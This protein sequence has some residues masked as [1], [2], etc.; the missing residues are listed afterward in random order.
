MLGSTGDRKLV[1]ETVA[2]H[3]VTAIVHFIAS[4]VVPDTVADPLGYNANN[5]MNT[6]AL[7]DTVIKAGVRQFIFSST[8]AI[9][10]NTET[11]P[12][13]EN[14]VG[15]AYLWLRT[16]EAVVVERG[17]SQHRLGACAIVAPSPGTPGV[18]K[19]R[20]AYKTHA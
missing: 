9:Y 20:R 8:A 19:S 3:D 14:A 1:A 6:C 11:M 13:R 2:R 12:I 10:G 7:L 16:S 5:T 17:V 15:R 18:P 4:I